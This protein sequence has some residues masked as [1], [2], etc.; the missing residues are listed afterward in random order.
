MK[1]MT[2]ILTNT[3]NAGYDHAKAGHGLPGRLKIPAGK[4][5]DFWEAGFSKGSKELEAER[6]AYRESP[7]YKAAQLE[8][9][10]RMRELAGA[11]IALDTGRPEL[12]R[13]F[14]NGC[15]GYTPNR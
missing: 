4:R 1:N 7:A 6:K 15:I 12:A 14:L 13:E 2:P 9:L 10:N 5:R 8:S 3:F 11:I